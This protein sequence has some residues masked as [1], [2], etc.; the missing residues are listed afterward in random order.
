MVLDIDRALSNDFSLLVSDLNQEI[1]FCSM[2]GYKDK[3][4]LF[5]KKET[6]FSTYFLVSKLKY[7]ARKTSIN[8]S[9]IDL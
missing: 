7:T 5:L 1:C 6:L 9:K 2:Q 4:S 3:D 8:I